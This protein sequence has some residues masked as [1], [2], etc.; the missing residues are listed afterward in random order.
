MDDAMPT[1]AAFV[2]KREICCAAC[3]SGSGFW[4]NL[5]GTA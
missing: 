4:R 5:V 2:R 3:P 1:I